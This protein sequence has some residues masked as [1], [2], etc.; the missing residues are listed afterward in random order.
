MKTLLTIAACGLLFWGGYEIYDRSG[1]ESG[2]VVERRY[3]P[4]YTTLDIHHI[5]VGNN[6]TTI[7]TPR[8]HPHYW[9]VTI[10]GVA[11]SGKTKRRQVTVSEA[12]FNSLEKGSYYT[13]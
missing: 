7:T 8:Y 10:E 6:T 13:P 12:T 2:T 5:K 3:H 11:R 9:T 4:A 1:I